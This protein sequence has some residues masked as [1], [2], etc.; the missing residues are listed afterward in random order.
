MLLILALIAPLVLHPERDVPHIVSYDKHCVCQ[1]LSS[2]RIKHHSLK[3]T[4]KIRQ[5]SR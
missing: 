1:W 5:T 4:H 2:R 3:N